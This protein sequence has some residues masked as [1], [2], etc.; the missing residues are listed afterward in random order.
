VG[1]E[2]KLATA[3]TGVLKGKTTRAIAVDLYGARRVR[4]EWHPDGA[5]RAG[6]RYWIGK[7]RRLVE[8]GYLDVAAGRS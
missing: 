3:L 5:L 4:E 7:A 2:G 6:A 1:W 8:G